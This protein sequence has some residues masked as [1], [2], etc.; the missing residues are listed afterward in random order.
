MLSLKFSQPLLKTSLER[1]SSCA[2]PSMVGAFSRVRSWM[3]HS[4]RSPAPAA[5]SEE[6]QRLEKPN[7]I[8]N[9]HYDLSG[10][11]KLLE[12]FEVCCESDKRAVG[13]VNLQLPALFVM[14]LAT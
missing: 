2:K 6:S 13:H 7:P 12:K 14:S 8:I 10:L 4:V 9:R 3:M 5:A 11:L 1:P